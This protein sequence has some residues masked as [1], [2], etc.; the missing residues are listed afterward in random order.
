M[1][2]TFSSR[3]LLDVPHSTMIIPED[4]ELYYPPG[5]PFHIE[6]F[7]IFSCLEPH[8]L[9]NVNLACRFF[10]TTL[11]KHPPASWRIGRLASLEQRQE[12]ATTYYYYFFFFIV[13]LYRTCESIGKNV[14]SIDRLRTL[15][16]LEIGVPSLGNMLNNQVI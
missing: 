9:N 3:T 10:R 12:R 2:N 15:A 7:L 11:E 13:L 8:D 4:P 16:R 1:E 5:Q 6:W 14:S